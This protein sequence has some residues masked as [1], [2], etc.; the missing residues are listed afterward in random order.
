MKPKAPG[1]RAAYSPPYVDRD[2][3]YGDLTIIYP[4]P[5]SIYFRALRGTIHW[6]ARALKV[7]GFNKKGCGSSQAQRLLCCLTIETVCGAILL[8]HDSWIPKQY[9]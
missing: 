2:G 4:R 6:E 7:A 9:L 8:S 3:E 5:Y 1:P